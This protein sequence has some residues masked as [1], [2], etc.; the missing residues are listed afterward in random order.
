LGKSE[1]TVSKTG[2][3]KV[4]SLGHVEKGKS[5][6]I[7]SAAL[8]AAVLTNADVDAKS[9]KTVS[10]GVSG[11]AEFGADVFVDGSINVR[12]NVIGSGPYIDSSDKRFKANVTRVNNALDKVLAMTGVSFNHSI[13]GLFLLYLC[14]IISGR[15]PTT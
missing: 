1:A 12:G 10:L 9:V 11:T 2:E 14:F 13:L 5:L 3:L 15:S 6:T 8:D 7:T 4:T